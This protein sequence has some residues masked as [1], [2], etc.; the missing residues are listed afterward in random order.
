MTGVCCRS[1]LIL[2]HLGYFRGAEYP[3]RL[4]R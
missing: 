3:A 1:F 2:W 4:F